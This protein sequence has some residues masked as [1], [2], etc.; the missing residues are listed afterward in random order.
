M[1]S[2]VVDARRKSWQK[3]LRV[4]PRSVVP[5]RQRWD[6]EA[7]LG[8]PGVAELLEARLRES[9]G[10]EM[11][12]ANPVTGRLLVCHDPT[13]SGADIGRRVREAVALVLRRIALRVAGSSGAKRGVAPARGAHHRTGAVALV[14]AGGAAGAVAGWRLLRRSPLAR[15][16]G[17]VAATV[18]VIW[19]AWRRSRRSHQDSTASVSAARHPLLRIVG[20]R[21]RRFYLASLL[22]VLGQLL[23]MAPALFLGWILLV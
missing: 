13:L 1:P 16:G 18:V 19:R 10:V 14:V 9:P 3:A 17:V 5:G 11:V 6:V 21:K 4:R 20:P 15:V 22:S 2:V 23:E 8:R 12:R 7:V